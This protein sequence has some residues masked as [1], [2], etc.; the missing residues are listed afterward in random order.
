MFVMSLLALSQC[1]SA[2]ASSWEEKN[3]ELISKH[4]LTVRELTGLPAATIESNLEP[5]Q[6]K[7]M[8][9][10]DSTVLYPGVRAKLFWGS[11]AMAGAI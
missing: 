6:V 4:H 2:P 9:R 11:G 8:D 7:S 5:A 1:T 3:K 10:L